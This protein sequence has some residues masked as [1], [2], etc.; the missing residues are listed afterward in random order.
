MME[1]WI[2]KWSSKKNIPYYFN[3]R[4]RESQWHCPD[5]WPLDEVG[6]PILTE[7]APQKVRASHLLVKHRDSRRP[8]SWRQAEDITRSKDEALQILRRYR[9]LITSGQ[10]SFEALASTESDCSS[11]KQNGDLGWFGPGQMQQSFEKA[12]MAL[13]VGE[14]SDIVDS[15]SGLHIILRTG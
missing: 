6:Q 4:T 14:L 12:A 15:D 10:A 11:A 9:D 8:R 2:Q 7:A 1:G 13:K 3:E 5:G